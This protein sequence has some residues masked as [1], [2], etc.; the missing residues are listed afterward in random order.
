MHLYQP[1]IGGASSGQGITS[2]QGC[3]S[4]KK[5]RTN[6]PEG[7]SNNTQPSAKATCGKAS[8]AGKSAACLRAARKPKPVDKMQALAPSASS[9]AAKPLHSDKVKACANCACCSNCAPS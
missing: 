2:D 9:V 8:M 4:A 7:A 5:S 6:Q 1:N 3:N